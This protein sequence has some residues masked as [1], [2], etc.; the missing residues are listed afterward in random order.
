MAI[1]D[2]D[3]CLQEDEVTT[4]V[5][6]VVATPSVPQRVKQSQWQDEKLRTLWNRLINGE[7]LEGW[8]IK[9]NGFIYYKEKAV[10]ANDPELSR[11]TITHIAS[12]LCEVNGNPVTKSMEILSHF[13]SGIGNG[14]STPDGC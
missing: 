4:R 2:Y 12:C 3:L 5:Y 1:G 6:N 14:W 10:V 8:E 13:H 7:H 11:P 9:A